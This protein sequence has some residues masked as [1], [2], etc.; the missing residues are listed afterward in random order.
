[1]ERQ[2]LIKIIV[3]EIGKKKSLFTKQEQKTLLEGKPLPE[4]LLNKMTDDEL[5]RLHDKLK[6]RKKENRRLKKMFVR[7]FPISG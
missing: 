3:T 7:C 4:Q 5:Q 6:E 1:M 2:E